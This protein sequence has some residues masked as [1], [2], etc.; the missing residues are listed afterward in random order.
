MT[1]KCLWC[2]TKTV[3]LTEFE[4]EFWGRKFHDKICSA[5]CLEKTLKFMVYAS[6]HTLHFAIGLIIPIIIGILI[7]LMFQ[8]T[9][10]AAIGIL[11]CCGGA[12]AVVIKYPFVN[13]TVVD[14]YGLERG[15]RSGKI[16][17]G[18]MILIGVVISI[19]ILS[20]NLFGPIG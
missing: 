20:T 14:W 15:I 10:G 18:I 3:P 8:T 12:G 11:I 13:K 17:G 1:E 2:N 6:T 7:P 16:V 5:E 4:Y 19:V 9:L